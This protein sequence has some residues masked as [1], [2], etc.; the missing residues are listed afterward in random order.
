MIQID[1]GLLASIITILITIIGLAAWTG[2]LSQ[3]VSHH[4][5]AWLNNREDHNKIFNKLDEIN[6]Y[7][8]NGSK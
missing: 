8:R 6:K 5:K 2:A 4:E 3:K 1:T 7:I